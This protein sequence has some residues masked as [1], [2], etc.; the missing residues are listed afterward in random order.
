MYK[1]TVS[2]VPMSTTWVFLGL[3]GGRELGISIIDKVDMGKPLPKVFK[4]IFKD[5][6]Y[7]LFG[8]LVSI[9]LAISINTDVREELLNYLGY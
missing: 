5:L 9:L 8:L 1:L 3:L 2:T 4:M 7:A 6:S